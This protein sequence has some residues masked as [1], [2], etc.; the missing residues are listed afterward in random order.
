ML[1]CACLRFLGQY[2]IRGFRNGL[3]DLFLESNDTCKHKEISR[4]GL[5]SSSFNRVKLPH[6]AYRS[7]SKKPHNLINQKPSNYCSYSSTVFNVVLRCPNQII[8]WL[9]AKHSYI[10]FYSLGINRGINRIIKFA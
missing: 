8:P 1:V 10:I 5:L 2:H 6:F 9:L 7:L 4:N 3:R